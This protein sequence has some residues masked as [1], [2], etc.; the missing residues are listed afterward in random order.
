MLKYLKKLFTKNLGIKISCLIAATLLWVYIA[1]GQNTIAKY[2]GSIKIKAINVPSGLVAIYDNKTVDIKIMAEPSVW[3]KLSVDSFSAYVDLSGQK[4]GTY[5][6]PV[7]VVSSTA[8]V[9]IVEKTPDKVVISL[10]PIVTKEVSINKKVEGSAAEGLVAGNIDLSPETTTLRGPKSVVNSITEATALIKLNGESEK[11]TKTVGLS[12]LDES[13]E[14]IDNLEFDPAEVSATV[15]IVKASNN[16]TVGVR[17]KTTGQ[18]KTGYFVSNISVSPSTVD[19][20][21]STS[22]LADVSYLETLPIDITNQSTDIEKDV[23]LDIKNGLALQVGSTSKVHIKISLSLNQTSKE[24]S[25]TIVPINLNSAYQISNILPSEIKVVCSG[26]SDAISK[27]KSS[28]VIYN[29]DFSGKT[30]TEL[31]FNF[32]VTPSNFKTPDN[33]DVVSVVPS[34]I[35]VTVS[36]K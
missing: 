32:N 22:L 36:K 29:L 21:G 19:I 28:D 30:L 13:G 23:A 4:E 9:D 27:L 24:L 26:P 25:A 3:S 17:V 10:E 11:F 6:L 1:A 8:G 5:E 34:S 14:V 15:A 18:P 12:A 33:V 7:N 20:T 31:V 16:K 2:P 35:N